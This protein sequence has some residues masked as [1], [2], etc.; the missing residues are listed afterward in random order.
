MILVI[1]SAL[2]KE[3]IKTGTSIHIV[4]EKWTSDKFNFNNNN[5]NSNITITIGISNL[6]DK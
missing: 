2:N 1:K 6:V 3:F 4:V 5:K